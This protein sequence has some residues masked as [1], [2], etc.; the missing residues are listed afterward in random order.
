MAESIKVF[1]NSLRDYLINAQI[2]SHSEASKFEYKYNNLKVYMEPTKNKTPHFWV[3]QN[4]SAAC[5]TISPVDRIS[6]S[7]GTDERFVIMW[8]NRPNINGE[9]RKHWA[10]LLKALTVELEGLVEEGIIVNKVTKETKETLEE[11]AAKIASEIITGAGVLE[12]NN[13]RRLKGFANNKKFI[14]KNMTKNKRFK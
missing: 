9:L 3:S 10:Y 13:S 14:K 12:S 2:D 7:L 5:Y 8:A 11:E 1:E 4:I 6:G